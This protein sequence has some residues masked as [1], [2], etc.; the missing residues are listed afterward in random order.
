MLDL[1][2][3]HGIAYVPFFPLGSAFPGMPKVT[4]APAVREVA[5]RLNATPAQIGLAW[6]LT[7]SPDVLLIPG[8][9]CAA[10]LE[11]NFAADDVELDDAALAA[12]SP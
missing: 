9:S 2:A 8:T 11:E 7:R 5:R 10:H 4:D 6:L 3:Q 12:L 1:C